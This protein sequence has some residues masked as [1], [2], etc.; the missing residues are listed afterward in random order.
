MLIYLGGMKSIGIT[1]SAINLLRNLDHQRFDVTAVYRH[2]DAA[3]RRRQRR[4]D[5]PRVRRFARVG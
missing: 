5:H 1:T 3:D 4:P 2:T